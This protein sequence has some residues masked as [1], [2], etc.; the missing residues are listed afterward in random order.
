MASL[1]NKSN[2]KNHRNNQRTE[3]SKWNCTNKTNRPLRGKCQFEYIVYKVEYM[4]VD[5]TIVTLIEM[6]KRYTIIPTNYLIKGLKYLMFVGTRK[7]IFLVDKL[8]F[9]LSYQLFF[10]SSFIYSFI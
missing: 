7:D 4:V 5:L 9:I 10:Y 8:L 1:I 3:Y 2:V 6:L